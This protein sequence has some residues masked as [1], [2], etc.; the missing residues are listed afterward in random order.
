[1]VNRSVSSARG[2]CS[3][4]CRMRLQTNLDDDPTPY[5]PLIACPYR[6]VAV[7]F[8]LWPPSMLLVAPMPPMSVFDL[9]CAVV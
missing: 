2:A 3:L 8:I 9:Q 7:H 1:M 4:S 6:V 5:R